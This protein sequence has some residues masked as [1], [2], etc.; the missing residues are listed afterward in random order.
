[1]R[2]QTNGELVE[3]DPID[4][5]SDVWVYLHVLDTI[6]YTSLALAPASDHEDAPVTV[7]LHLE[8][9]HVEAVAGR[10]GQDSAP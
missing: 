4:G 2:T 6:R 7:E 3:P 5:Q 10:H 9:R 8:R 1:M